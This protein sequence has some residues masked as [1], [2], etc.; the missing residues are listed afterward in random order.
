MAFKFNNVIKNHPYL[1]IFIKSGKNFL[2]F[3]NIYDNLKNTAFINKDKYLKCHNTNNLNYLLH[4]IYYGSKND[5][6]GTKKTYINS[7]FNLDFYK[8]NYLKNS[9]EDPLLDFIYNGFYN[10]CFINPLD[11]GYIE[12]LNE[13]ISIQ[14][15]SGVKN[16]IKI[17]LS[18]NH[19]IS[20][21]KVTI[22]YIESKDEFKTNTIKV[23]VF[24]NDPFENLAP[25]PYLRIHEP[26]KE[27]SKSNKFHFFI[28]GMD[29]YHLMD[30]N[31]ILN[32]KVFDII[33]VERILPFLDI[34]L[35]K[36]LNQGIKLIYETDDDLLSVEENSPS[37]EYVNRCRNEIADFINASDVVVTATDNL[38]QRFNESNVEVI[39]NYH[40]ANLLPIQKFRENNTNTIKIGYFGTKTHSKDLAIIKDVIKKL[41][42]EMKEQH[43]ILVEFEII[44]G[45]NEDLDENWFSNI[46]LPEN[47]MNFEIFMNWLSQNAN[48]DIG[49]A[50]LEDSF[51]N[52]GKSELKYIEFSALG[53]PGVF[54]DV[55]VYNSVVIDGFNGY[56]ASNNEEW[57]EKL[58]KLVLDE[59]L[60]KDFISNA[61]RNI[62]ENYSLNDRV[63]QWEKILLN[64]GKKD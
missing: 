54:S 22:P 33:I 34:L 35:E 50:P 16:D 27:L 26:L 52:N 2:K 55:E 21:K 48:W 29:S 44:G 57:F 32:K 13:D 24:L 11:N 43:D 30:F 62:L 18:I 53:I 39:K 51:F 5:D 19:Y 45:F 59:N 7:I 4:Y 38:A 41:K 9:N 56:L 31:E 14:Y 20:D 46:E 49:I 1:Y 23:G 42:K 15:E 36:S 28:Y 63:K 12:N 3:I 37:F 61:Q 6:I 10:S 40:I 8:E 58:Q 17:E 25:C 47:S 64:L 60:R